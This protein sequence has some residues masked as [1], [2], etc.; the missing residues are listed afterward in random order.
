[1]QRI[2]AGPKGSPSIADQTAVT[3]APT[4]TQIA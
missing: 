4:P 1:M 2:L 3:V